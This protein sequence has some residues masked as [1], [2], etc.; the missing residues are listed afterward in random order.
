MTDDLPSV[1]L[2]MLATVHGGASSSDKSLTLAMNQIKSSLTSLKQE[3][4][5]GASGDPMQ[6]MMM[7]MMMGGGGGAAPAAAPPPEPPPAPQVTQ[8]TC[9][10]AG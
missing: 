2:T 1:D 10:C 8:V 9:N 4:S 6:M 7:M 5:G 3:A